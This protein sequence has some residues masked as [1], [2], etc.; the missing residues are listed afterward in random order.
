MLLWGGVRFWTCAILNR[1]TPVLLLLSGRWIMDKIVTATEILQYNENKIIEVHYFRLSLFCT[2]SWLPISHILYN[3]YIVVSVRRCWPY[4]EEVKNTKQ[5]R[6][7]LGYSSVCIGIVGLGECIRVPG[8]CIDSVPLS[9]EVA[10]VL[11][12]RQHCCMGYHHY[13]FLSLS[14]L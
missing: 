1:A 14:P 4:G 7:I 8:A 9:E 10:L 3:A 6:S 13:L 5:Y 2:R 11:R 12:G